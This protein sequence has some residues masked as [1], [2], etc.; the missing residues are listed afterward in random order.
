MRK[1]RS[2]KNV[3]WIFILMIVVMIL[4]GCAQTSTANKNSK[5]ELV[6]G[7]GRS[8]SLPKIPEKIVSL[9]PSN[10]ELLF[11][12]GAGAQVV[13]R[14]E[15]SDYPPE[16]KNLASVGGSMGKYS[17]EQI[18]A[19]QPDLVLAAEINTPEQVKALEDLHLTV[20]YL[21]NPKDLNGM[22]DNILIVGKLTGRGAEAETLVAKLKS[23]VK[24]VED[25]VKPGGTPVKVFYE[26]DGSDPSKP[27][28]S[29][30]GSFVDQLITMAGGV[31]VASSVGEGW[32]QLSQEALILADPDVILLGDAAYG[33]APGSVAQRAGWGQIS[34]VVNNRIYT[35]DDNLV[36]RP[37]PR[38]VDGLEAIVKLIGQ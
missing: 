24:A 15:F 21:S 28:T 11:A 4:T 26:L 25:L 18:S 9:A 7:L 20:Y 30:K 16:A 27:W 22:F 29:G 23:R 12:V 37:G 13:G 19:L 35:F 34:A 8:V 1:M 36:S 17:Y 38:L 3:A 33:I 6:D 10:T 32:M 2:R 31:N 14:D 5:L